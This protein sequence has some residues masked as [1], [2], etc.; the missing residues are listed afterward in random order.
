MSRARARNRR[1]RPS[2]LRLTTALAVT[3]AATTAATVAGPGI[4]AAAPAAV[5]KEAAEATLPVLD[6]ENRA[7]S[8]GATGFLA[9]HNLYP[10]YAATWT[11][12][13][14]TSV[15]LPDDGSR[16]SGAAESDIVVGSK[17][18]LHTVRDMA[19]GGDP[20]VIDSPHELRAVNG[21]TLV[22][23]DKVTDTLHL[24]SREPGG[25]TV[26]RKVTG[27]PSGKLYDV[28][29]T[30]P[31][32]VAV[33]L[34]TGDTSTSR[35]AVIDVS[36]ATVIR[37][38]DTGYEFDRPQVTPDHIAWNSYDSGTRI[39]D[40]HTGVSET[41]P[42][43]ATLAFGD[44]WLAVND[45]GRF[46]LR[47]R[48]D[49][50]TAELLHSAGQV[51]P[52]PDG[53]LLTGGISTAGDWG[54]FRVALGADGEPKATMVADVPDGR[55]LT[56]R[57]LS[58]PSRTSGYTRF[59]WDITDEE[60]TA[61][62][63][64]THT[65]TGLTTTIHNEYQPFVTWDGRLRSKYF[66]AYN[67]TYT[68]RLRIASGDNF[69]PSIERTG[70]LTMARP[71]QRRDFNDNGAADALV[72]DGSG[73]LFAYETRELEGLRTP[74]DCHETSC[75]SIGEP[76]PELLGTGGW[77]IYTLLA[78][79]GNLAGGAADDIVGRDRDG[80]LWLYQS[81]RQKLLPRTK[82]GG[83]W[84]IYN[85]IVGGSDLNGDGRGDLLATDTTGVLWLYTSTGD[86]KAPFKARKKIG[87]GWGQYNLLTAPGNIA[88]ATGGDLLA[89]DK[90]GV[91]WLYL[92][93]GDGTFTARRQIGGGWQKYTQIIPAGKNPWHPV[94]DI[95][96]VGP[97]GSALY[98]GTGSTTRPF[99]PAYTL[100]VRTDSTTYKTF[101]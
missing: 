88:G 30:A 35:F 57:S 90:D 7:H 79:P 84:Q 17:G 65:A 54:F 23:V 34:G 13:D 31:G 36:T 82:I 32:T 19:G 61:S 71:T 44:E 95:L 86:A 81:E 2:R 50:H 55:E 60:A 97:S 56:L 9:I 77:N 49:G 99:E 58:V 62:I 10:V 91:L 47:S 74:P 89:R 6:A 33:E 48:K 80:V 87:S 22:M 85:K 78:S 15:R 14:G 66:S 100:P 27:L 18:T 25:Q 40:R 53:T 26:D 12:Y 5:T 93:K 21:S 72:R 98:T 75:S 42:G 96:A 92:G 11:R 45:A 37:L 39:V 3:L 24:V 51:V 29:P 67:G 38:Y 28:S 63:K 73:R 4:A 70:T 83:G 101:F 8:V 69:G 43:R 68:W 64:L 41:V 16:Y 94:T 76:T 20:V 46:T 52:G 59:S 1:V